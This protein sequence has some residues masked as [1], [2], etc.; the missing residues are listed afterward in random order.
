MPILGQ[1]SINPDLAKSMD[2]G[3]PYVIS[4]PKSTIA[5]KYEEICNQINDI[6][7]KG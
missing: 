1:I 5:K 7:N 4:N 2:D 6:I 3:V